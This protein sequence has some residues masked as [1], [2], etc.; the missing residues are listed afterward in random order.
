MCVVF[1]HSLTISWLWL[2]LWPGF[3][4]TLD[5]VHLDGDSKYNSWQHNSRQ[6]L[7]LRRAALYSDP[8]CLHV[9]TDLGLGMRVLWV[10]PQCRSPAVWGYSTITRVKESRATE[11]SSSMGLVRLVL[12]IPLSPPWS[13]FAHTLKVYSKQECKAPFSSLT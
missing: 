12:H 9:D 3:W 4:G 2:V 6:H 5:A 11:C 10:D 13:Y 7:Q 8:C 1:K